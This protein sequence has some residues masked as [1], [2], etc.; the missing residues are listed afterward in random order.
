MAKIRQSVPKA[1][2]MPRGES[3]QKRARMPQ[4]RARK[5]D[6]GKL[7]PEEIARLV[8]GVADREGIWERDVA[9]FPDLLE[10]MGLDASSIT[11]GIAQMARSMNARAFEDLKRR[12]GIGEPGTR[13]R[14]ES[15]AEP[16]PG[17]AKP[18]R[19]EVFRFV[20]WMAGE[21]WSRE[22]IAA[23]MSAMGYSV[24]IGTIKCQM[25]AVKAGKAEVP[26]LSESER[27]RL[28]ESRP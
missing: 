12:H 1:A 2:M 28:E 9:R 27:K 14:I 19:G 3:P 13:A 11:P 18:K 21:G 17:P 24:A 16:V 5:P 6:P 22:D 7:S 20:R 8:A 25:W 15:P 10:S 4:D 23:S 26:Q